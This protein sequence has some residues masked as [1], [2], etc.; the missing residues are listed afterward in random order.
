MSHENKN[1]INRISVL[2]RRKEEDYLLALHVR[3]GL[4][5]K[6]AL[7]KSAEINISGTLASSFRKY[8]K[9]YFC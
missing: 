8:Q 2:I 1:R 9:M 7:W 3:R 4:G 5:R 6:V